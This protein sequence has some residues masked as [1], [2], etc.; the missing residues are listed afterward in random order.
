MDLLSQISIIKLK[1]FVISLLIEARLA[2][3]NR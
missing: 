1:N 2:V 3:G